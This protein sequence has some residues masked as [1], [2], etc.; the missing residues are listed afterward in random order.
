M[1]T[2]DRY[3]VTKTV[4]TKDVYGWNRVFEITT[5]GV[6]ST[7]AQIKEGDALEISVK[8]NQRGTDTVSVANS[9]I[10]P[11]AKLVK[12]NGKFKYTVQLKPISMGR[13]EGRVIEFNIFKNGVKT[14]VEPVDVGG[15][16]P[17]AYTFELD[18]KVDKVEVSFKVD[19]MQG[20][21][22]KADLV[23]TDKA[24]APK[25]EGERTVKAYILSSDKQRPSMADKALVRDVKLTPTKDGS[26]YDVVVEFKEM[27]IQEMTAGV[28]SFSIKAMGRKFPATKVEGKKGT[29]TFKLPK[30]LVPEPNAT[31]DTELNLEMTTYPKM[32]GHEKPYDVWM[33]LDWNGDFKLPDS[34]IKPPTPSPGQGDN[35]GSQEEYRVN[36]WMKSTDGKVS[37]GNKALSSTANVVKKGNTYRY[38]ILL[39]PIELE[40][41]GKKLSGTITSFRVNGKKVEPDGNAYTFELNEKADEV[42]VSFVVDIMQDLGVG[43]KDAYIVFNWDGNNPKPSE[44]N[45][46]PSFGGGGGAIAPVNPAL[47]PNQPV[48]TAEQA[49]NKAAKIIALPEK[50]KKYYSAETLKKVEK[51]LE[52]QK[53]GE[54]GASKKLETVLEEARIER[55]TN[56]LDE[57]Y[58]T[59]YPNKEFKPNGTMSRAEASIMF[60]KLIDDEAVKMEK[61]DIKDGL[62]YSDAVNKLASLGYL[63]AIEGGKY[64]PEG[65]ITRAEYAFLLAKLRNLPVG[66]KSFGD[67]A[68]D[69]WAYDAIAAC[70]EAGIIVGYA[71]GS[72]NPDGEITR[73]EAVVMIQSTFNVK[74][75]EGLKES[76][77]DVPKNHWAY[78]AIMTAS[79]K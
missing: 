79:K 56:I 9:A 40:M 52:A 30:L 62:W 3:T 32:K 25:P 35:S 1:K 66:T 4:Y 24:P 60:A 37:V 13:I 10:N 61:T 7:D 5:Q 68:K 14:T 65:K 63:K 58:M 6:A 31:T 18:Q 27:T 29:F 21:E 77:K 48:V 33:I 71:D 23:F 38:T 20:Q 64:N 70:K 19:A 15:Q 67:V 42:R 45:P 39:N 44:E 34:N 11:V 55:I 8:I 22:V 41:K 57:G 2:G 46:V 53:K 54:E 76:F 73:A 74:A 28:E 49:M 12:E 69:H 36:V 26:M 17:K 78:N 16:Y 59:G 72:F 75:K 50:E 47:T 51:A 43:E